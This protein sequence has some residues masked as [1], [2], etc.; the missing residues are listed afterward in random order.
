MGSE[1]VEPAELER[2]PADPVRAQALSTA[3]ARAAVDADRRVGRQP[4]HE[5]ARLLRTGDGEAHRTISGRT[6][7][8]S[9]LRGRGFSGISFTT[10]LL[11]PAVPGPGTPAAQG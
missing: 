10:P 6:F 2:A 5:Q 4:W 7:N 9:A 8:R 3:P 1:E 11:P